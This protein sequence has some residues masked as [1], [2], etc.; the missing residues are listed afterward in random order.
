MTSDIKQKFYSKLRSVV[1]FP[2][3]ALICFAVFLYVLGSLRG[4]TDRTQFFLLNTIIYAGLFTAIYSFLDFVFYIAFTE[5]TRKYRI[6]PLS[7]LRVLVTKK[8]RKFDRVFAEKGITLLFPGLFSF[9]LAGLAA[10]ILVL[11]KG[12]VE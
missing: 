1:F 12:N 9:I 10:V 4:F 7:F 3:T 2:L 8:R 11:S 6:S 5:I